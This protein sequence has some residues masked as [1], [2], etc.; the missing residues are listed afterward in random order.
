MS[1][2]LRDGIC[3]AKG[4]FIHLAMRGIDTR[5]SEKSRNW[6]PPKREERI[7]APIT[8]NLNVAGPA[9]YFPSFQILVACLDASSSF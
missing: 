9:V 2:R 7:V 1:W 6:F 8:E 3:A 5:K 4:I